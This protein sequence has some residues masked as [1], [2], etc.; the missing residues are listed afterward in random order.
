MHASSDVVVTKGGYNSI[1]EAAVGGARLIVFPSQV[2]G[3]DEQYVHT[4][5]L[6][7][8]YPV[9]ILKRADDLRSELESALAAATAGSTRPSFPLDVNGTSKIREL[10]LADL[11]I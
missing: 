7:K 1:I 6:A 9:C 11:G 2:S 5:R 3:V 4:S 8:Y 10:V